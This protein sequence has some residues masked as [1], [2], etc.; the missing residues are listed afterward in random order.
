MKLN[1]IIRFAFY[2]ALS[3]LAGCKEKIERIEWPQMGTIAAVQTRGAAPEETRKI[4]SVVK[5]KFEEIEKLLNRHDP[6]S[7]INR[8]SRLNDEQILA[9]CHPSV[10]A[11]YKAAFEFA[12]ESSFSF[13]PRWRGEKTLDLGAIAKGFAV[14]SAAEKLKSAGD[15]DILIDL[16]GNLKAVRGDWNI[17]IARTREIF[18]LRENMACATSAKYFRGDHIYDG[19]TGQ[20]VSNRTV[21]TT[22]VC[23]SAMW[24]D[25][26]STLAFIV[27]PNNL[28]KTIDRHIDGAVIWILQDGRRIKRN[29]GL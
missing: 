20:A 14:D 17:A 24:A 10:R 22:A 25:A 1:A 28:E 27:G 18:T 4:A 6:K 29:V 19:R 2:S 23:S 16:G 11:C 7:E 26:A 3:I 21:S 12:N 15:C 13:N 5:A 8:L 9:S